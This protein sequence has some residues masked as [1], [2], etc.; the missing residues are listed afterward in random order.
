M[1][2]I[3]GCEMMQAEGELGQLLD[4]EEVEEFSAEEKKSAPKVSDCQELEKY[5]VDRLHAPLKSYLE[6]Q[7]NRWKTF[8]SKA[9]KVDKP[10]ILAAQSLPFQLVH[11]DEKAFENLIKELPKKHQETY[12]QL[13]ESF[14][15]SEQYISLLRFMNDSQVDKRSVLSRYVEKLDVKAS[16]ECLNKC[17]CAFEFLHAVIK[18]FFVSSSAELSFTQD[19]C[20]E[21]LMKGDYL[22]REW[23]VDFFFVSIENKQTEEALAKIF[24]T[25]KEILQSI[26]GLSEGMDLA[27]FVGFSHVIKKISEVEPVVVQDPREVEVRF[28]V[29]DEEEDSGKKFY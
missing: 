4:D 26:L 24:H 27:Q 20:L 3:A 2:E 5:L 10:K 13:I 25:G 28:V 14:K 6:R 12:S 29:G 9:E 11:A 8:F 15:K 23:Y 19:S 1:P 7:W 17:V 21:S 18:K 22:L 16:I